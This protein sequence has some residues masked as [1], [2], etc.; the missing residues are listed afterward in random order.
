M[1]FQTDG[2][3]HK[4]GVSSEST[5]I[6]YKDQLQNLYSKKIIDFIHKGGTKTKTDNIIQF[7]DNIIQLLSVKSKKSLKN[8]SFDWCN[9][10]NFDKSLIPNTLRFVDDNRYS[11]NIECRNMLDNF[12]YSELINL[13]DETITNLFLNEVIIKYNDLDLIIEDRSNDIIYKKEPTIFKMIEDGWILTL[14]KK[15]R[16]KSSCKLICVSP[17]GDIKDM[18]LRIRIHLNNGKTMWLDKEDGK[19]YMCIKFQQ[20]RINK[21]V[22]DS[23]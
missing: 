15:T 7:D 10:S 18:G 5:L 8:G 22:N 4:T 19:S 16:G 20:D 2:S 3:S 11:G 12:I 6:K 9:L 17:N 23:F 14:D 21:F 13:T 1:G